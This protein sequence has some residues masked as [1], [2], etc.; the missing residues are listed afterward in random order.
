MPADR[1]PARLCGWWSD[2]QADAPDR[3]Y[4]LSPA[5]GSDSFTR[6]LIESKTRST[7]PCATAS[8]GMP[9][10]AELAST[11][12]HGAQP[13]HGGAVDI[14]RGRVLRHKL[15]KAGLLMVAKDAKATLSSVVVTIGQRQQLPL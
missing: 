14:E 10:T 2:P 8:F 7:L 11:C 9:K 5:I 3:I 6:V 13:R 15:T 1:A 12:G 4:S